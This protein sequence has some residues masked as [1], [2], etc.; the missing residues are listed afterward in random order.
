[1]D[2]I[3][4]RIEA[5]CKKERSDAFMKQLREGMDFVKR[6]EEAGV[7][8]KDPFAPPEKPSK[9]KE[10]ENHGHSFFSIF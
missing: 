7:E 8:I 3:D 4:K 2:S 9:D 1:M 10:K 6:L 5:E